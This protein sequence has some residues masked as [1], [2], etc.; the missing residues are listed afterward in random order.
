MFKHNNFHI[1][2][3]GEFMAR[4]RIMD[5]GIEKYHDSIGFSDIEVNEIL[6]FIEN[7]M[8][9]GYEAKEEKADMKEFYAVVKLAS[10]KVQK[11]IYA[12]R[13]AL[14]GLS[15]LEDGDVP[16][17]VEE[18]F[19][20]DKKVPKDRAGYVA[21]AENILEG[22]SALPVEQPDFYVPPPPFEALETALNELKSALETLSR[23]RAEARAKKSE[24]R[25]MRAKGENIMRNIYHHAIAFW[26][27][28]DPRL[29]ELGL[30]DKSGIWTYKKKEGE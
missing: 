30:V 2:S 19:E 22:Y 9:L 29:L 20:L 21:M 10:K 17:Y 3:K 12:C 4:I 14:R 27:D 26:G 16:I 7:Y 5:D 15:R 11:G 25:R 13:K 18:R 23:E 6:E 8:K 1:D 24:H 28:E